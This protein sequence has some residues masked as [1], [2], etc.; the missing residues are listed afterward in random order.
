MARGAFK[1]TKDD[2]GGFLLSFDDFS[3]SPAIDEAFEKAGYEGGGYGWHGV[4]E[5]LV[6][7]QAP[8]LASKLDYDPEASS[9]TISSTSH[10]AL[11]QVGALM[12]DA[13]TDAE[14]LQEALKNVDPELMD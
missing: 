10:E 14:L 3:A 9:L 2:D 4:V 13:M 6:R 1:I 7:M 12:R 5:A 8:H 11:V